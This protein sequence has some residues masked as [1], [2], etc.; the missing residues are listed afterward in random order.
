MA[1]SGAAQGQTEKTAIPSLSAAQTEPPQPVAMEE[2]EDKPGE[3]SMETKEVVTWSESPAGKS[4]EG[5]EAVTPATP[6]PT[7]PPE[8]EELFVSP[9]PVGEAPVPAPVPVPAPAAVPAPVPTAVT[10]SVS[11]TTPVPSPASSPAPAATLAPPDW[12]DLPR[13]VRAPP[14]ETAESP[15]RPALQPPPT[16]STPVQRRAPWG[17]VHLLATGVSQRRD[18]EEEAPDGPAAAESPPTPGKV[19]GVAGAG[20]GRREDKG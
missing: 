3:S 8:S 19:R 15:E 14:V 16:P 2:G 10:T 13:S 12:W 9:E 4:G 1:S 17:E 18:T 6:R 5:S 7:P 11:A 20:W